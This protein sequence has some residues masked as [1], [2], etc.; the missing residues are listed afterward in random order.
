MHE[1]EL[2]R[3]RYLLRPHYHGTKQLCRVFGTRTRVLE[4]GSQ[5]PIFAVDGV[6]VRVC[7]FREQVKSNYDGCPFN[8]PDQ[9][10]FEDEVMQSCGKPV[11]WRC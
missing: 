9:P 6:P 8:K 7:R 2:R 5:F 4:N 10:S 3:C 11:P 1:G